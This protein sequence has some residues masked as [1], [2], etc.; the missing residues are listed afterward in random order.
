MPDSFVDIYV[1]LG[2]NHLEVK[3]GAQV[4]SP[5]TVLKHAG[6]VGLEWSG[7]VLSI[8]AIG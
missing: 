7:V 4:D 6:S 1:I 5:E 2:V 8:C 3:V